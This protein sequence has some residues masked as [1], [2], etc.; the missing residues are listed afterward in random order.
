M[1]PCTHAEFSAEIIRYAVREG[2]SV[3]KISRRRVDYFSAGRRVLIMA[4]VGG[5]VCHYRLP[6]EPGPIPP[7]PTGITYK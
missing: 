7:F 2:W 1:E 4:V 6:V 3:R 5:E